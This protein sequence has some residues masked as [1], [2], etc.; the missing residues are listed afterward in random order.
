MIKYQ[1]YN[2]AGSPVGEYE[3]NDKV[4]GLSVNESLLHQAVVTQMANM[5]KVI[6]HTKTRDEV[7]GSGKKP[8]KQKGTGRARIG[9]VRSPLWRSGGIVFGP[10]KDRNFKMELNKKMGRQAMLMAL[11]DKVASHQLALL[12]K[13]EMVEFKTKNA[14]AMLKTLAKA[15]WQSEETAKKST[16]IINAGNDDKA[17][18]SLRN[19]KHVKLMNLDNINIVDLLGHENLILTVDAVKSLES[20]IK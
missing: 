14:D 1:I 8:W 13:L 18:Y 9:S 10:S 17:K 19:L 15:V 2:Q 11:S 16:L 7:S 5:R 3:L 12:D 4:F 6:A 20:R